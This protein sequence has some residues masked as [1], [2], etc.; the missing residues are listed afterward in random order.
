MVAFY[1]ERVA[2][3]GFLRTATQLHSV[4]EL[5]RTLGYGL[6][7][8]VAAQ[9]DLAFTVET[10]PGAP[11]VTTVDAGT[12]V[13]S[14]PGPGQLPQT[15]ETTDALEARGVWNVLQAI[16]AQPQTLSRGA[17]SLWLRGA[18]GAVRPG[19]SLLIRGARSGFEGIDHRQVRRVQT[20]TVAPQGLDGWLQIGLDKGI[21]VV[22]PGFPAVLEDIQVDVFAER[23]RLFGA[24]APDPNLLV[25]DSQ[26]PPGAVPTGTDTDGDGEPDAPPYAW[27]GYEVTSPVDVDGDHP[28]VLKDSWLALRQG[29]STEIYT[30]ADVVRESAAK[31][32]VSG[33]VTLATVT[34][35]DGL[36]GFDRQRVSVLCASSGLAGSEQPDLR[37]L[38][39]RTVVVAASDPPLPEGRRVLLRGTPAHRRRHRRAGGGGDRH[40]RHLRSLRRHDDP[41]PG[42]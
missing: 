37:P 3:E 7:P 1:S 14:V 41:R 42:R 30:V 38:T 23:A 11:E 31:W 4:R 13:Q 17:E 33:P 12:P 40:R 22:G 18:P 24:N 27:S 28:G 39:G 36:A 10:A 5:A 35:D 2:T 26:P 25:V 34:P 29:D 19:D 20:V 32:T 8:G 9:A 15:F 21:A 6:R 16:D